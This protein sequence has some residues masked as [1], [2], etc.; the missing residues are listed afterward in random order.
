MSKNLWVNREQ[1]ESLTA[2]NIMNYCSIIQQAKKVTATH[3]QSFWTDVISKFSNKATSTTGS[4]LSCEG[5]CLTLNKSV[6][7]ESNSQKPVMWIS[8]TPV[9]SDMYCRQIALNKAEQNQSS[10]LFVGKEIPTDCKDEKKSQWWCLGTEEFT[11]EDCT[12]CILGDP[13]YFEFYFE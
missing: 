11:K 1:S 6:E 10:H 3:T 12:I 9:I 7:T 4:S 5:T 13:Q 2:R 8:A